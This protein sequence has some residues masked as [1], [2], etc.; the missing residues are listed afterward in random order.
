MIA[1]A[2]LSIRREVEDGRE[3]YTVSRAEDTIGRW[4]V[5]TTSTAHLYTSAPVVRLPAGYFPIREP[6]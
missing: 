4:Q 6:R 2:D 3:T 1:P 5:H